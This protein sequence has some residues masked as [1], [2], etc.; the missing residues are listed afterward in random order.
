MPI[1]TS[2]EDYSNRISAIIGDRTD[3][4]ALNFVQDIMET[5]DSMSAG[6]GG[7]TQEQYDADIANARAEVETEWRTKYKN[8]FFKGPDDS[9]KDGKQSGKPSNP[10]RDDGNTNN[11]TNF[12]ELFK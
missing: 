8:A 3:D 2:R 11:P 5:Y 6:S 10:F 7:I 4:D 1:I 12:D 9:I